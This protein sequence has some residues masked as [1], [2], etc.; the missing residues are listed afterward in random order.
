M[1]LDGSGGIKAAKYNARQRMV[2][3]Q[4]RTMRTSHVAAGWMTEDNLIVAQISRF[5]CRQCKCGKKRRVVV[6]SVEELGIVEEG[7]LYFNVEVEAEDVSDTNTDESIKEYD[8]ENEIVSTTQNK[9]KR[10]D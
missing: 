10:I 9:R 1:T 7:T 2:Q 6:F 5:I 4:Q 8:K 3:Q